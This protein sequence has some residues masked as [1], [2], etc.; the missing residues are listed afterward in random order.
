MHICKAKNRYMMNDEELKPFGLE[1]NNKATNTYPSNP[2]TINGM[3]P[4]LLDRPLVLAFPLIARQESCMS[5]G[6]A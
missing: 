6:E 4:F 3:I 1:T 5:I 2:F